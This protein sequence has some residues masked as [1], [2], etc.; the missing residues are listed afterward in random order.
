MW[1]WTIDKD[2]IRRPP[3]ARPESSNSKEITTWEPRGCLRVSP[4]LM[5]RSS[6]NKVGKEEEEGGRRRKKEEDEATT[7]EVE[8]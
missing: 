2:H 5:R 8:G 1:W 6:S 4:G 3:N 7:W